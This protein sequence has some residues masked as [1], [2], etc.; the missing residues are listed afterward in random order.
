MLSKSHDCVRFAA[1]NC[2]AF[3]QVMEL[4]LRGYRVR[5]LADPRHWLGPLGSVF[6]GFGAVR[7]SPLAAARLLRQG[8][9]VLLFPGGAR[10][11]SS[12]P[13]IIYTCYNQ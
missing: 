8:E 4:Y 3:A 9:A 2:I 10:E 5:G 13:Q 7:A 11:V 12:V 6:E 1:D